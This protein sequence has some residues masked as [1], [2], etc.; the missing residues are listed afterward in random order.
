MNVALYNELQPAVG[1]PNRQPVRGIPLVAAVPAC[2]SKGMDAD[3][4]AGLDIERS[5]ALCSPRRVSC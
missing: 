5:C 3:R 2:L 1:D 4:L